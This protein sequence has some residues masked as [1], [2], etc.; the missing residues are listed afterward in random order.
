M[1]NVGLMQNKAMNNMMTFGQGFTNFMEYSTFKTTIGSSG[2]ISI[3]EAERDAMN[4]NIGD[5]VQVI[6]LP[7][8]QR[9]KK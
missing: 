4:L 5:L 7:I 9:K 3:P 2:R 1:D 6:I 8:M